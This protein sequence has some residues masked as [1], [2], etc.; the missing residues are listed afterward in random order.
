MKKEIWKFIN[1][2]NNLYQIS[3]LGRIR[4]YHNND[5]NV[6]E[7]Y[8]DKNG[9][10]CVLLSV[11]GKR[12]K[13][14]VHTIVAIHFIINPNPNIYTQIN[15]KDENKLNNVVENLEW[16]TSKYNCNY[17]NRNNK[18]SI[19][20]YQYTKNYKLVKKWDSTHQIEKELNISRGQ[21][22]KAINKKVKYVRG[23]IWSSVIISNFHIT[24]TNN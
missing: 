17:G 1:N 5:V 15:H 22:S 11:D 6:I 13:K 24:F 3:N 9:Y 8:V 4:S 18:M 19:P 23:Y 12:I 10:K 20:I 7:G 21:I 14:F 16:C 2:T